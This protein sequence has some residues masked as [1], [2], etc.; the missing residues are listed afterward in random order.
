MFWICQ[1][2][3]SGTR[4]ARCGVQTTHPLRRRPNTPKPVIVVP[5][6][7]RVGGVVAVRHTQVRRI[8]VP[9][10]ATKTSAFS[11][12]TQ[13]CLMYYFVGRNGI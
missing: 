7:V 8:V 9:I 1:S 13:P 12:R 2:K 11:L 3:T 10:A 5:I 6:R 4:A